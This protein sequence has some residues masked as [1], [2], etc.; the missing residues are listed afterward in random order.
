MDVKPANIFVATDGI[1]FLGNYGSC[2]KE[3]TSILSYTHLYH[4]E[5][6]KATEIEK[7]NCDGT[8][9]P[10]MGPNSRILEDELQNILLW[11]KFKDYLDE[12]SAQIVKKETGPDA[13]DRIRRRILQAAENTGDDTDVDVENE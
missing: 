11:P 9:V 12:I 1:W 5:N 10:W 7:G 4:P 2:V 6:L 13:R 3:N 8:P